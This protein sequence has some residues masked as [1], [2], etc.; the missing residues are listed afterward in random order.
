MSSELKELYDN[1][2][3]KKIDILNDFPL[4][5]LTTSHFDILP[6][7]GGNWQI[8]STMCNCSIIISFSPRCKHLEI[9]YNTKLKRK[10]KSL[11]I[12]LISILM[13]KYDIHMSQSN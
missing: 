8:N 12:S 2:E 11:L 6:H 3:M 7:M 10:H 1:L 13:L 4:I 5:Y 9:S